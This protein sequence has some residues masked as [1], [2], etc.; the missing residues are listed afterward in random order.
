MA[1]VT[2]TMAERFSALWAWV[3]PEVA[4]FARVVAYDRAGLGWSDPSIR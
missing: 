1:P 2:I 3:Q 4:K